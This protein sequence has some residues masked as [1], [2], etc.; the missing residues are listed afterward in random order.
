MKKFFEDQLA[1]INK[2]AFQEI[3]AILAEKDPD[4]DEYVTARTTMNNHIIQ[5]LAGCEIIKTKKGVF[6]VKF[7]KPL[8]T[9]DQVAK[10][11]AVVEKY[12]QIERKAVETED[13]DMEIPAIGI[14][15]VEK[16][17][18][19]KLSN[20]ILGNECNSIAREFLTPT[21]CVK[22]AALGEEARKR[23][24]IKKVIIIGGSV[25]V[26]AGA[27]TAAVMIIKKKDDS[28]DFEELEE[29]DAAPIEDPDDV[30][31]VEL[32]GFSMEAGFDF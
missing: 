2:M 24:N 25:I 19:K 31:E 7:N 28:E 13:D 29:I 18:N 22:I 21:D 5:A 3:P 26:L 1:I 17:N 4:N 20:M 14:P 6:K 10:I 27:A 30:P 8:A 32:D 9:K 15:E 23:A 16:C 11:C 12:N